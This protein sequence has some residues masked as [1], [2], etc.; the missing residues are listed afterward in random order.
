MKQQVAWYLGPERKSERYGLECPEATFEFQLQKVLEVAKTKPVFVKDMPYQVGPLL[1]ME[2]LKHFHSSF[3]IRDPAYSIP[4]LARVWPDYTDT[5]IG[6]EH[7]FAAWKMLKETGE[8]PVIID[9]DDIC[10]DPEGTIGAWCDAVG[11]PRR[12]DALTWD[13]GMPDDWLIWKEW[14]SSAA[15]STHFFNAKKTKVEPTDPEMARRIADA[16][17]LYTQLCKFKTQPTEQLKED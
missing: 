1:N 16:S 4:S 14:H 8:N 15:K 17:A 11:I 9:S 10:N 12:P 6:Y 2:T 7:L 13:P 3:L 5:E